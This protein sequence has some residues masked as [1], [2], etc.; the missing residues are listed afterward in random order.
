[1]LSYCQQHKV[2]AALFACYTDTN[3]PD[4]DTVRAFKV[5]LQIPPIRGIVTVSKGKSRMS[6]NYSNIFISA[7][8]KIVVFANFCLVNLLRLEECL[9]FERFCLQPVQMVNKS[10]GSK[11]KLIGNNAKV[12]RV[13]CN[14]FT[15]K[16][17]YVQNSRLSVT[18][19]CSANSGRRSCHLPFN[20]IP[21]SRC[22]KDAQSLQ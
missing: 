17:S 11:T 12:R 18:N 14:V 20:K 22:P 1:M 13:N 9:Q 2:D 7:I 10:F 15:I 8:L 3:C 21:E 19:Y 6:K 4:L 16:L 5:L